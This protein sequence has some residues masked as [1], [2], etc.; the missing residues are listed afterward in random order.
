MGEESAHKA[1]EESAAQV[2]DPLLVKATEDSLLKK[3]LSENTDP[4]VR[5]MP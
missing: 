4:M 3:A 2:L 1:K 5:A